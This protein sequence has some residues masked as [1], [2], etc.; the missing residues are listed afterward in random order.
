M[1]ESFKELL[2]TKEVNEALPPSKTMRQRVS[3]LQKM[4]NAIDTKGR[5]EL[6]KELGT[7]YNK[8]IDNIVSSL[9]DALMGIEDILSEIEIETKSR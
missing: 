8:E 4:I 5:K 9:E 2:E 1:L 7:G 6:T 3:E